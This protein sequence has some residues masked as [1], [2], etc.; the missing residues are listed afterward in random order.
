[1]N[2][3]PFEIESYNFLI[4]G[5]SGTG[6]T[7]V[8]VSGKGRKAYMEIDI[9]SLAR[10]VQGMDIDTSLLQYKAYRLPPTS[11]RDRGRVSTQKIGDSGKGAA[12]IVHNLA[13]WERLAAEFTNDFADNCENPEIDEIIIDTGTLLWDM[14][15]AATRERIQ[16][17]VPSD[18]WEKELK[19]LEFEE[20]N[21]QIWDMCYW[22]KANRKTLIISSMESG[23]WSQANGG[24]YIDGQHKPDGNKYLSGFV[25][26]SVRLTVVSKHPVGE[27]VKVAAGGMELLGMR[28]DNPTIDGLVSLFNSAASLRKLGLDLPS[29]S[30]LTFSN[31]LRE[32]QKVAAD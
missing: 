11:L 8:A 32:A 7:T 12:T 29:G 20:P 19:R 4:Y 2:L 28:I 23:I 31:V 22:A 13:G 26:A 25:D 5:M 16:R 30:Q 3:N 6:K 21:Q 1:M 18:S 14:L 17:E 15:Q 27:L 10:A 9:G 24:G